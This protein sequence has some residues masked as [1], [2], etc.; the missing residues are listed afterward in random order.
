MEKLAKEEALL[1]Y[2]EDLVI[3]TDRAS[4]ERVGAGI[5]WQLPYRADLYQ[6]RI[7]LG[8]GKEAID[9]ELY[10]I[11]EGLLVAQGGA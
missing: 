3:L 4:Q 11:K 9:I 10:T 7:L 5:V 2:L 1:E 8:E 6:Y